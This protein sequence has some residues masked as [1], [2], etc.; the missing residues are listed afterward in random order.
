MKRIFSTLL[1]ALIISTPAM[2]VYKCKEAGGKISYQAHPC[3]ATGA[4]GGKIAADPAI[5]TG[6]ENN[7]VGQAR[8]EAI[9]NYNRRFDAATNQKVMRGMTKDQVTM[10]W[11]SPTDINRSIGSYGVHEQWVYRRGP[12]RAQYVYFENGEVTSIQ[13]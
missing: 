13:D 8:L 2:A 3:E 4:E 1:P 9:K 11:G 5:T 10:A 6:T 7:G 12:G